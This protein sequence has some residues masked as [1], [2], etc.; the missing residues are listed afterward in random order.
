MRVGMA[1]AYLRPSGT[2]EVHDE[3]SKTME[4]VLPLPTG[5]MLVVPLAAA[6]LAAGVVATTTYALVHGGQASQSKVVITLSSGFTN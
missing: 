2:G 4:H 6:V 3:R 5:R 1:R